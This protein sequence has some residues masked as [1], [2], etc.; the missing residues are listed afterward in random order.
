M[1]HALQCRVV[2]FFAV[3]AAC[4]ALVALLAHP[5]VRLLIRA[6]GH[7]LFLP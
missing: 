6:I 3:I 2:K 7:M 1:I 5:S 4:V